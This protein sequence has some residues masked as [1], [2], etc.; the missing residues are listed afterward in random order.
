MVKLALLV[1]LNYPNEE[2]LLLN[3]SYNDMLLVEKYLM[4]S[5]GFD[6]SNI[7]V[8]SDNPNKKTSESNATFFNIVK[9]IKEMTE[10]ASTNDMLFFYFTGHGT[11]IKDKSGDEVDNLDEVF[12]PSDYGQTVLSDDLIKSLLST[13][14]ANTTLIFDCCNSGSVS[15]LK[16]LYTLTPHTFSANLEKKDENNSI[17]CFSASN[18]SAL[19]YSSVLPAANKNVKWYSNFTYYFIKE[20]S[21]LKNKQT[22]KDLI[23]T[24][25]NSKSCINKANISY[26]NKKLLDCFF[27]EKYDDS[28]PSASVLQKNNLQ[29]ISQ[30]DE[31]A[32]LA[33]LNKKLKKDI[34]IKDNQIERYKTAL[35][36]NG[37]STV[38]TFNSILYSIKN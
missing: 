8:L 33:K 27:L 30:R 22:N 5:E 24:M 12:L 34:R 21:K 3:S 28:E 11:Q 4:V 17:I 14:V 18:D 37:S 32:R 2:K 7:L 13:C 29:Q 15:D 16:Y 38:D 26:S 35:H 9:R 36:M 1:G 6:Q 25:K 19:T 10:M 31:Y 20:L 23:A